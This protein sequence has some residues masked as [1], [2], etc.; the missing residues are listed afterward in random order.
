MA[1]QKFFS[2]TEGER[3]TGHSALSFWLADV[4]MGG[5]VTLGTAVTSWE[6]EEQLCQPSML[7]EWQEENTCG[8][9]K[10]GSC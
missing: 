6:G 9:D 4:G 7:A 2:F 10:V 3:C 1:L 5:E 8:L